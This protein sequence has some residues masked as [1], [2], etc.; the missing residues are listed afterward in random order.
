MQERGEARRRAISDAARAR[1]LQLGFEG[2]TFGDLAGDLGVSKAAI[3]YYFPAKDTFLDEFVTPFLDALE[4]AVS[5]TDD[6]RGVVAAYLETLVAH[7]DVAVWVDTDPAV[8]HHDVFGTRL[9]AINDRLTAAVTGASSE[10]RDTIRALA[11]LG[12]LW[13]P[14]RQLDASELRAHFDEI[15]DAALASY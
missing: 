1:L 11:V 8:Q 15:V 3:A 9:R 12:G 13:R 7:H 14:T 6:P 5:A 10:R 2:T 4:V